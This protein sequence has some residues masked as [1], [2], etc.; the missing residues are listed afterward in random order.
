VT[1]QPTMSASQRRFRGLAE[2]RGYPKGSR[3]W[4]RL[5]SERIPRAKWF[6][7]GLLGLLVFRRCLLRKDAPEPGREAWHLPC[8]VGA[9]RRR[10]AARLPIRGEFR[11]ADQSRRRDTLLDSGWGAD[12][13]ELVNPSTAQTQA[14]RR[15]VVQESG[16]ACRYEGA[17]RGVPINMS[18]YRTRFRSC[19]LDT[20]CEG[21]AT[22][23]ARTAS[24]SGGSR[25]QA[26]PTDRPRT[27]PDQVAG[28]GL[29]G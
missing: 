21:P 15:E 24:F 14:Y 29:G 6:R 22:D 12:P 2:S 11:R 17:A 8:E 23:P 28:V 25:L 10:P 26:R 4:P 20:D 18:A 9:F 1:S 13:K 27:A 19:L 3:S 16:R 5:Q 7:A